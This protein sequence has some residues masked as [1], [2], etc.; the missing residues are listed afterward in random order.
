MVSLLPSGAFAGVIYD[1]SIDLTYDGRLSDY[2]I[3]QQIADDFQLQP[4]AATITD[5]HWWG[6]YADDNTATEP[7]DFTI[8]FYIDAGGSPALDPLFE[9]AVGDVGRVDSGIDSGDFDVYA[10]WVDIAALTLAADTTF[11]LSIVNDTT[12]DSGDDWFWSFVLG[13]N[14]Y[15]RGADG[16][17][18]ISRTDQLGFQLTND[19]VAVPEPASLTLFGVGLGGLGALGWRRR[20]SRQSVSANL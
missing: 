16:S 17:T 20:K 13:G 6:V 19:A 8:R 14:G 15:S 1:Q 2:D 12:A 5:I 7:D 11:W 4:G 18:W 9:F 10:Y 3:P